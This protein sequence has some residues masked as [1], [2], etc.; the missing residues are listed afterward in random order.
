[1]VGVKHSL[2]LLALAA[3][4]LASCTTL[5]NRRDMY[6]PQKVNGP[7]TRML[8]NGIPRY[9]HVLVPVSGGGYS[10]SDGKSVVR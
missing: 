5:E 3:L 4:L 9:H 8:R 7:Y 10:S 6:F 1:V 2:V